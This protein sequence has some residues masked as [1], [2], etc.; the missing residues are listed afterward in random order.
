MFLDTFVVKGIGRFHVYRYFPN[1]K[2]SG[3]SKTTKS[4]E[5]MTFQVIR[6]F[7]LFLD[8]F[9]IQ[10]CLET[11]KLQNPLKHSKNLANSPVSIHCLLGK[12]G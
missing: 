10:K 4:L 3:N 9:R 12:V 11:E 8:T 6:S 7:L 5:I 2:V 1:S